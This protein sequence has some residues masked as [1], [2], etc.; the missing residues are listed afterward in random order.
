MS[1]LAIIQA[2]MGSSRLSGKVMKPLAGKPVLWHVIDRVKKSKWVDDV[3]VATTLHTWDLPVVTCCAESG[4]RVYCGSEDDVLDR[5]YQVARILKPEHIVRITADCPLHDPEIIDQVIQLHLEKDNDYT[6]NTL[7]LSYPDG[8]DC[9]IMKYEVLRHTWKTARLQSEREHVTLSIIEGDQWKKGCLVNA[10]DRSFER[11][12]L[13]TDR[14]YDFIK[15]I[16]DALYPD[17]PDFTTN[18]IYELLER[19]PEL[20]KLNENQIRNEGL[21]KSLQEDKVVWGEDDDE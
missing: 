18:D 1:V 15:S 14:D 7:Q 21:Q 12:T 2:R 11:W 13:D 8:L 6:S 16:Y 10:A 3:V 4:I 9:E 19:Q 5:Y 20:R 17:N